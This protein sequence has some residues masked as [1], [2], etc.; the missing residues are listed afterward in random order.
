MRI[1][2]IFFA[3]GACMHLY[4]CAYWRVKSETLSRNEI[5]SFLISKNIDENVLQLLCSSYL[6][7]SNFKTTDQ[8]I[9]FCR[10]TGK[11]TLF[12]STSFAL[13]LPRLDLVCSPDIP[14]N[15]MHF[16][17][18]SVYHLMQQV[19]FLLTIMLKGY[20]QERIFSHHMLCSQ[21]MSIFS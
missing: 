16:F 13:C 12:V 21:N 19:I 2:K 3:L 5:D 11:H 15:C 6:F 18:F 8:V 7:S 17:C 4:A 20:W 10:M 9:V 1:F 14:K